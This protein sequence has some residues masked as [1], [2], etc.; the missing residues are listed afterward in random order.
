L[1]WEAWLE[2][3]TDNAE[4]AVWNKSKTPDEGGKT[5]ERYGDLMEHSFAEMYRVLK[6]GRWA[7]VVFSNS[8]DRVWHAIQI[9][10]QKAGFA[11]AGSGTLDKMQRSFKG[12]K[13]VKGDESVVTKDVIMN[14]LKPV[15][16]AAIH[17]PT[18]IGDPEE[19]VRARLHEYLAR[20][21]SEGSASEDQR[22]TQ[23]LYDYVITTLLREHQLA[24]GFGLAFIQSVAQESLKQVDGLWY[25]RGDRVQ[26]DT[27]RMGMDI[28]DESS[29][30]LWL[31]QRLS[32][33]A[34]TEAEVIPEF[35][36]ASAGTHIVGGIGRL[37][38]ENFVLDPRSRRWR[39]PT[40]LERD[41]L[42]DLGKEQRRRQIVRAAGEHTD[43]RT[44]TELLEIVEEA[45]HLELYT[46]ATALLERLHIPDLDSQ[47]RE[48]AGLLRTVIDAYGKS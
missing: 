40:A 45:V 6:P 26:T 37:L 38:R 34:M 41:A 20:L 12:V 3:L 36:Q 8:D 14:L 13:G 21:A 7:T 47:D 39:V 35:N 24:S 32:Y 46:E 10:A 22:T 25:R 23:A 30:V 42:N 1:Y 11:V 16:G 43:D 29:A 15:E 31:D 2:D 27:P 44:A 4:E 5:L 9:A 19:F 28:V 48:R 17:A 18:E 33:Q